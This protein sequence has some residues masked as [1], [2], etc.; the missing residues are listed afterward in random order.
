MAYRY[1]YL[2]GHSHSHITYVFAYL[3]LTMSHVPCPLVRN[4]QLIRIQFVDIEAFFW[5]QKKIEETLAAMRSRLKVLHRH[6]KRSNERSNDPTASWV[7]LIIV[8]F[9]RHRH[10]RQPLR[11]STV[12]RVDS[13]VFALLLCLLSRT[14]HSTPPLDIPYSP[15][16]TPFLAVIVRHLALSI[17]I[18]S[19]RCVARKS[20]NRDSVASSANWNSV[21]NW[22]TRVRVEQKNKKLCWGVASGPHMPT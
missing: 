12:Q 11:R 15:Y 4:S 18:Q 6:A 7:L 20:E 22:R 8:A 19:C 10:Q 9:H 3:T 1:S 14:C 21:S 13:I 5:G 16:S 17:A 2:L